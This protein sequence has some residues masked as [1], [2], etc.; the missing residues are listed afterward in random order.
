MFIASILQ[1]RNGKKRRVFV[2]CRVSPEMIDF[3]D[4]PDEAAEVQ[5]KIKESDCFHSQGSVAQAA[6]K[7]VEATVANAHLGGNEAF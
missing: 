2:G 1:E 6:E 5:N 4:R 3:V 7:L